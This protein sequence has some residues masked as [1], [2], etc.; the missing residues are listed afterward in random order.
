MAAVTAHQLRTFIK[1]QLKG[2]VEADVRLQHGRLEKDKL[3]E[4]TLQA[5]IW[6]HL[7]RY[8]KGSWAASIEDYVP[9]TDMKADIVLC[10]LTSTGL[11]DGSTG[12]VAIEV[13][14]HGQIRP[15]TDDLKKLVKYLRRNGNPVN[16]GALIYLS[17]QS[18]YE[19]KLRAAAQRAAG[20]RLVVIRVSR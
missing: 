15:L 18:G 11:I 5:I 3:T 16:F 7:C 14:P 9:N 2:K 10:K 1:K 8:V 4:Y 13:K 6:D 17:P 20:D 19:E 12:A